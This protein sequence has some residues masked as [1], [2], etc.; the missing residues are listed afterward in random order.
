MRRELKTFEISCDFCHQV[1]ITIESNLSPFLPA[2]WVRAEL[3]RWEQ[4]ITYGDMCPAC[5]KD[6]VNKNRHRM[7]DF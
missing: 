7:G 3:S 1:I 5:D 4:D 6:E 2:G